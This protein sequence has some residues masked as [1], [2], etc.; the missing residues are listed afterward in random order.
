MLRFSVILVLLVLSSA[1]AF[2][3]IPRELIISSSDTEIGPTDGDPFVGEKTLYLWFAYEEFAAIE[4]EFVGTFELVS[5]VAT[6]GFV[7]VGT[8]FSPVLVPD[9]TDCTLSPESL[10]GELVVRDPT[11]GGAAVWV[12]E[13]STSYRLCFLHCGWGEWFHMSYFG[14]ATDGTYPWGDSESSGCRPVS[15]DANTWG[16]VKASYR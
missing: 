5:F 11:G 4:F 1:S 16:E 15:V 9:G 14:Y 12:Q 6:P 10:I 3:S 13:S 2:A 7:N 8:E